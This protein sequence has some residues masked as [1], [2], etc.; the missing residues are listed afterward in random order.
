MGNDQNSKQWKWMP[1]RPVQHQATLS[2]AL[3]KRDGPP[4]REDISAFMPVL[5]LAFCLSL[6]TS[7]PISS[8]NCGDFFFF[9]CNS[10]TCPLETGLRPLNSCQ[11]VTVMFIDS[12]HRSASMMQKVPKSYIARHLA[13]A[14][15]SMS[16]ALWPSKFY[17]HMLC[18]SWESKCDVQIVI[19]LVSARGV[20]TATSGY[21]LPASAEVKQE[22]RIPR[23][24]ASHIRFCSACPSA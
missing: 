22:K 10:N 19:S 4:G 8:S 7:I 17:L 14:G 23:T 16:L 11:M 1:C 6:P 9:F 12:I 24:S 3:L 15:V 20:V 5:S 2:P 13:T 21:L 18:W